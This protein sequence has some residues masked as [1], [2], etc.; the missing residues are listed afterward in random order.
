M[1]QGKSVAEHPRG[2]RRSWEELWKGSH[3]QNICYE[4]KPIFNKRKNNDFGNIE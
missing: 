1:R 3:D 2:S 4:N